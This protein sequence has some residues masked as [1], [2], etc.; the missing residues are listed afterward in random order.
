MADHNKRKFTTKDQDN[1][2]YKEGNCAQKYK[3][4]W[5]YYSCLATN[6]NGLY[7]RG[8]HEMSGI[9]LYWSGWTVTNDSLETTEMKIRP[10]NFKKK[11]I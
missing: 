1:D 9:G 7:L 8:K 5:W 2:D 3:G 6:L 11:Y 4:G 10:K